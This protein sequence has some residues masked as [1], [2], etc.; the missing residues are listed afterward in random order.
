MLHQAREEVAEKREQ[1]EFSCG[2][3]GYAGG[4]IQE[5]IR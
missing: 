2:P 1:H 5:P 4:S 3:L